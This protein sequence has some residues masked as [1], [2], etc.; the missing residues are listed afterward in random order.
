MP[1]RKNVLTTKMSKKQRTLKRNRIVWHLAGVLV[2]FGL[3]MVLF[4]S[5]PWLWQKGP[6]A[7]YIGDKIFS[8]HLVYQD[9]VELL[10]SPF[11]ASL[12][13]IAFSVVMFVLLTVG[14]YAV[15]LAF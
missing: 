10:I 8:V 11:G 12:Y 3:G 6:A 1:K 4:A 7:S 5:P 14:N 2:T 15:I 9:I 13:Q